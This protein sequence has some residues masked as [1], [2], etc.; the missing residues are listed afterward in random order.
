MNRLNL[1]L[2][3]SAENF[4]SF[5][6]SNLE[7][8]YQQYFKEIL[9]FLYENPRFPLSISFSGMQ[10]EYYQ[11][12]HPESIKILAELVSRRQLE[13][14]GGSFYLCIFPLLLSA[15]RT[16]QIEMMTSAIRS[17]FGKRP[18]GVSLFGDVWDPALITNFQSCGFDYMI[19]DR[20]LIPAEKNSL[21]PV[22]TNYLG[23]S[24]KILPS[25]DYELDKDF[26]S[27]EDFVKF[28][29][30]NS[31]PEESQNPVLLL[32]FSVESFALFLKSKISEI[33]ISKLKE[34]EAEPKTDAKTF[35][36]GE[37]ASDEKLNFNLTSCQNFIK[38]A[39]NFENIYVPSGMNSKISR[40]LKRDTKLGLTIYDFLND[41]PQ[42]KALFDRM[43]YVSMLISQCKGGDKMRKFTANE[44]LLK[45]QSGLSFITY[46]EGFPSTAEKRQY[47]YKLLNEAERLI[48]DSAKK[49]EESLT[50][51]DYNNDGLNEYICQMEKFHGVISPVGG[52]FVDFGVIKSLSNGNYAASLSRTAGFDEVSDT[53]RRGILL[54]HFFEKSQFDSYIKNNLV[55]N[56]FMPQTLFFEKKFEAKRKE[57][58]LEGMSKFSSMQLP[59]CVRKNFI[60]TSNGVS[61]QCILKNKGPIEMSGIFAVELNLAQ[62]CFSKNFD[63]LYKFELI[64]DGKRKIMEKN[65]FCIMSG[66]SF[67]QLTSAADKIS[68]IVEPN[69]DSGISASSVSFVRPLGQG[70]NGVSSSTLVTSLFW[71]ITIPPGMEKEKTINLS[72]IPVK[73]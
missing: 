61:V 34:S 51:F 5:E 35:L 63:E 18:R 16:S 20:S 36:S 56:D 68:F 23:K 53:Y 55:K 6:S 65:D 38:T 50:V 25:R 9:S 2:K 10:L 44:Y 60:I 64:Q 4:D 52:Q 73:K 69:E 57:I 58:Y 46:P 42:T 26:E 71:D 7:K 22:I 59:L 8:N 15:D 32:N 43:M 1:C 3:I 39:Y 67:V 70:K 41:Y 48:R 19:L 31:N 29:S 17:K 30:E 37:A 12:R 72:I 27:F 54:N 28:Y 66:I 62:L 49:F 24:I 11:K 21:N 40:W 45:A 14:I 47:S 13:I 33:I